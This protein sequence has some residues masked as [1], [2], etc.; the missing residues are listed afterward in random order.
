MT[1]DPTLAE[2]RFGCGLSPNVRPPFDVAD[3]LARLQAPDAAARQFPIELFD[4]LRPRLI[5]MQRIRKMRAT[6]E[7]D[8][9][10]TAS[11]LKKS[12]RDDMYG[13]QQRWMAQTIG[14]WASTED[15]LRE[16]LTAFW[17]DHFTVKGSGTVLRRSAP[18]Y[19][20]E[21]I[22]PNLTGSFRDLLI[23]C[24]T[25]P[26]MLHF[27]DQSRSVGPNSKMAKRSQGK[28]GLNENLAREVLELHTLGVD[29]PYTQNDV[30]Q[31]AE[32]FTGLGV[33][34]KKGF[35]FR[36]GQAEPGAENILGQDYGGTRATLRHVHEL[37]TDLARH[38]A[39]ARHIC[40]KLAVYFVADRPP[41]DLVADMSQVFLA[42]DGNLIEVYRAMLEHPG[43]WRNAPGN[44]KPPFDYLAS[45]AR[46]LG[47]TARQING[48]KTRQIT[49]WFSRPMQN[50]G[51]SWLSPLG[52]DGWPEEDSHWVTPQAMA[53]RVQWAF[54]VPKL[55]IKRLPDPRDFADTAL[56]DQLPGPVKFAAAA[57]ENRWEGVALV[58][59]SPRFQRR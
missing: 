46:A 13:D 56:A 24:V 6:G 52:P 4:S 5:A 36:A 37:L 11:A 10:A 7:A 42:T 21:A 39:T 25:H 53:V 20:E 35:V 28:K 58:L 38:P 14:R 47:V 48:L 34:L 31:L 45:A 50:M 27:L 44:V 15:G 59:A 32:L 33:S 17:A 40:W 3:M 30:R 16:R 1:F 26:M 41:D 55:L 2:T 43:A 23:A 19:W 29:G 9:Q 12:L 49:Q 18:S 22:R 8:R 54:V 57:A 51:Q